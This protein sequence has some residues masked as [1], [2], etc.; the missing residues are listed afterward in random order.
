MRNANIDLKNEKFY[1]IPVHPVHP[2]FQKSIELFPDR[3][4][5]VHA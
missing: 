3:S 5:A 1:N 2:W 4:D